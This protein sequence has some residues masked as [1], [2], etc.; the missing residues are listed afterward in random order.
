MKNIR[1]FNE[2][3]STTM[4]PDNVWCVYDRSENKIVE[5][6]LNESESKSRT[7][8]MNQQFNIQI[9]Q[10]LRGSA[11][12]LQSRSKREALNITR[13]WSYLLSEAL[14]ELH[15]YWSDYYTEHDE[16]Y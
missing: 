14:D 12:H 8:E 5:L 4:T 2:S 1:K 16:S 7:D 15:D 6:Y 11:Q 13:Y 3:T 10:N 9:N